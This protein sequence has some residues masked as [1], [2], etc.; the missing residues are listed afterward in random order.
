MRRKNH[1][2]PLASVFCVL[3]GIAAVIGGCTSSLPGNGGDGGTGGSN[4]GC[5]NPLFEKTNLCDS[6]Y[7]E[8][9]EQL[10]QQM[11]LEEKVQQMSGRD[12]D[13]TN[14]FNQDDNERLGIP[15][16]LYMD[17]PR[18]VRWYNNEY[19]T[20]VFPVSEAR[21]SSWDLDL[22]QR[23]GTACAEEMRYLGRHL[24]LAP[25]INQVTHP[26]WGRA[27]ESYGEDSFLLGEMGAAL[28]RGVQHDPDEGTYRVLACV[29]HYAAN[30]V[31][32][33]RIYVNA[34]LDDRTL[35]EVYIPHFKKS[36]DAGAACVMASYNQVN[37]DY[38]C[39][40]SELLRDILKEEWKF[41][42]F[43][44]SD[45][46]AKGETNRSPLAGLDIE[47]PFSS[48]LFPEIF[49]S[50][51]FYGPQLVSA[52]TQGTVNDDFVDEAAFRILHA[53]AAFGILD[54]EPI[55]EPLRTKSIENQTLALEAAREGMTLLKNGPQRGLDDDVLP[56]NA[57]S[58]SKVGVVG[59]YADLL[60]TGDHGSS[61]AKVQDD[62]LVITPYEGI[63]DHFSGETVTYQDVAGNESNLEDANVIVVVTAYWP[64]DLQ[65]TP[66]G[67]EG[68]WKDREG[69]ALVGRD[70][71][72]ISNALALRNDNPGMRV[73]VVAKSGGSIVGDWIDDVDAL[74][75]AWFGGM[76]EGQALA[77]ILFG[78]VNP[79]AK[80]VQ[81]FPFEESDLPPYD[82]SN[83]GDMPYDYY[84][85]Y[86]LLDKEGV[87]P[88]YHF[89]FGLSYT[90][91]AY[92]NLTVTEST[93]ASN[94]TLEVKVDVQNTGPAT[95]TEVVQLYVGFD[96]TAVS[97]QWGRPVKELRAFA[98]LEDI[99]SGETRTATLT[100]DAAD[101]AYWNTSSNAW[102]VESMEYQLYVGPSSDVADPNMQ[103]GSFT[104]N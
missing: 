90:T 103:T 18:G 30:N 19:G 70:L 53:K 71:T 43:A 21:A 7:A 63:R 8:E 96:N 4:G 68:E 67:E 31:E 17:G 29:K 24:F 20:T 98:R 104:V 85:G 1:T 79:S 59:F 45:W 48:G 54:N 87:T 44:I 26:R 15:G 13:P 51:Y 57:G 83:T 16:F 47:M 82:T 32:D 46:F 89:G 78:D 27:Q 55:F 102:E 42:G 94:G 76:R 6:P 50:E 62:E 33:P 10:L 77:E 41:T 66:Q 22:E 84:H 25:T 2:K 65:R 38:A 52:V 73:V 80:V 11:S 99:G 37:G 64:A 3:T 5:D 23:I 75:M 81:S 39:Y 40:N 92:S 61:D 74:I 60:N 34:V 72:N 95:G 36:V 9:A 56:L 28:V 69:M 58:I 86:R 35:R 12:F 100:V 88:R 49:D 91:Y 101:L 97:D 14:Y 93:I